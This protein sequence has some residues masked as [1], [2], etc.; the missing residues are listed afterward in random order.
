[1]G[2]AAGFRKLLFA[3]TELAHPFAKLFRDAFVVGEEIHE[4]L[5]IVDMVLVNHLALLVS[6]IDPVGWTPFS[7]QQELKIS[8]GMRV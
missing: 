4:P 5:L 1:M 3:Q 6:A 8:Y 2:P 7:N